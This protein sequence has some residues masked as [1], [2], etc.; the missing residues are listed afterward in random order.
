ML[1]TRANS[2]LLLL[3]ALSVVTGCSPPHRTYSIYTSTIDGPS[4]GGVNTI[5]AEVPNAEACAVTAKGADAGAAA[6]SPAGSSR[7]STALCVTRLPDE[8]QRVE[9][10]ERLAGA[11]IVKIS[12]PPAAASYSISRGLPVDSPAL[13]C[14]KLIEL[15]RSRIGGDAEF[16]CEYPAEI[17]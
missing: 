11:Y 10:G 5:F 4:G 12:Y 15:M 13:I 2:A 7:S 1:S 17:E 8:L 16:S 9:K 14:R 6:G 3:A